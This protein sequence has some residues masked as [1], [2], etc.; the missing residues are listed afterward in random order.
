MPLICTY[1]L[2][3]SFPSFLIDHATVFQ[4]KYF[5]LRLN[6]ILGTVFI[7][8]KVLFFI[9]LPCLIL[10]SKKGTLGVGSLFRLLFSLNYKAIL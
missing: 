3:I 5:N 4:L 9:L 10:Y 2:Q 6:G 7:W 1:K 8:G